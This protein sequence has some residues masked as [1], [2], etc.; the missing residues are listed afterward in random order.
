MMPRMAPGTK[1]SP[2]SSITPI[3]KR[4]RMAFMK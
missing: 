3:R 1:T 2:A 4:R